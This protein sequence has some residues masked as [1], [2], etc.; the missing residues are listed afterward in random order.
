[1][2]RRDNLI[3]RSILKALF[4]DSNTDK[5]TV[6]SR[7]IAFFTIFQL[8]LARYKDELFTK[9]RDDVWEMDEDEY[10]ESFRGQDK[11][12]KLKS[13]GDLGYSGSTFFTT[14]NGKFL[15]KS[16][17]RPSEYTYFAHD[18]LEPYNEHMQKHPTSLL[19]R[20]TDFLYSPYLTLGSLLSFAPACHIVMENILF[21]K[22]GDIRG[23]EWETY[24]LKPISYFYPERD[25]AGGH[26]ASDSVKERLVDKFEDKVRITEAHKIELL[27]ALQ[28]DTKLLEQFNAVDYS[29]FLVRY[30]A[31][32]K[33]VPNVTSHAS[34][35]RTGIPSADGKWI[36]RAVILDFFWAKHKLQ[37]K[38]MTALINSFNF[39]ARKGPMSLT[40]DSKEY[41]D[42]FLHMVEGFMEVQDE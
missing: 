16:L 41:R 37:A 33:D 31:E 17:P 40:T 28:E 3:S 29:L 13:V 20:I 24:D 23:D 5:R 4:R 35:W 36:Y 15:I 25:L 14:P 27:E 11:H 8:R 19:V 6:L 2:G 21:G 22:D 42:R 10:R 32:S 12:G 34:P 1:M 30:P 38:A 26:L 9:L 18:L 7:V 39:F